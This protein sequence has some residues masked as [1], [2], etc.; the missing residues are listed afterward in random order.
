MSKQRRH[1]STD[2]KATVLK[3]Y[4]VDKVPM[5]DLCDEYGLKPNLI[6]A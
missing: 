6:Y 3:R 5:S 4:L 2:Q 1:F